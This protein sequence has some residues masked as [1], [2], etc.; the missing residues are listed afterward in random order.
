MIIMVRVCTLIQCDRVLPKKKLSDI[1]VYIYNIRLISAAPT[2][3]RW[4]DGLKQK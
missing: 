2:Y 3:I 1:Y 4:L